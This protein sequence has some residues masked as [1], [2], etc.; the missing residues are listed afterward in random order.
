MAY[1]ALPT[2]LEN[3]S[4]LRGEDAGGGGGSS[5]YGRVAQP[6]MGVAQPLMGVAQPLPSVEGG[7][8]LLTNR[9]LMEKED[10]IQRS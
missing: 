6:L 5:T 7:E 3:S 8:A 1:S 2:A 4:P 9:K 10:G